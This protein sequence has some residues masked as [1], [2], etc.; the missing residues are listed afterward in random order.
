MSEARMEIKWRAEPVPAQRNFNRRSLW[1]RMIPDDLVRQMRLRP[2]VTFLLL[3]ESGKGHVFSQADVAALSQACRSNPFRVQSR[4]AQGG[5]LVWVSFDPA[6]DE[7]LAKA[8]KG[9]Q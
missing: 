9:K 6:H 4:R 1:G 3:D 7:A 5:R 2:G 8:R